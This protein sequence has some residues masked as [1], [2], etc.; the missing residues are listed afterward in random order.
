MR[1]VCLAL[2]AS[3]LLASAPAPAFADATA[4][5]GVSTTP[6]RRPAKGIAIGVSLVI[7]GFEFEYSDSGEDE[8]EGAPAL[9]TGMGNVM[10]QTP[11]IGGG[12]QFYVTAGAG[13]Y[14]ERLAWMPE[15]VAG[16]D[17]QYPARW[18]LPYSIDQMLEH[19]VAHPMR[20]RK[21]LERLMEG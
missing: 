4:F 3:V 11:A 5:L 16:A 6:A 15:E 13:A 9:R 2:L 7:V 12:V 1:V 19:A 8:K 17:Q 14:R 21:Q 20:H 18:K 10:L